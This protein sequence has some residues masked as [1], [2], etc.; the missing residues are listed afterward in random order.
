[1]ADVPEPKVRRALRAEYILAATIAVV[2]AAV[3]AI[4]AMLITGARLHEN[5]ARVVALV[6]QAR[7]EMIAT[8]RAQ[9]DAEVLAA[10]YI[11]IG[12]AGLLTDYANAKN[13]ARRNLLRLQ[14]T[15][16]G[17][18]EVLAQVERV[19]LLIERRFAVLDAEVRTPRRASS[20]SPNDSDYGAFRDAANAYS[21]LLNSRIDAA[22]AA[23]DRSRRSVD[24]MGVALALLSLVASALAIYALRRERDQWRVA[25][26]A[27]EEARKRAIASDLAKTRF[28]ATASHDMRQPL[29]ALT[30][31]LTALERRVENPEARGI[32]E[33]MERATQAMV[34]MFS[35]LLDLARIQAGVI[36]PDIIVFRL[37][38]VLDRIAAEHPNGKLDVPRT[39]LALKSDPVLVER[40][41]RNFVTNAMR[42]GGGSARI[43]ITGGVASAT[44]AVV[45]QGPGVPPR[46][47]DRIFEEFV[48]LD[49][50][51]EG[52]GLGLT[53]VKRIS[54]LID[55][56]VELSC[57]PSGG[58]RFSIR[59]P[60]APGD[61]TPDARHDVDAA[62]VFAGADVLVMD[63]EPLAR[64]AIAGMLRD[65]G[66]SVR[67]CGNEAELN[68]ILDDGAKPRLLVVDLRIDG[69]LSGVDI[70]ERAQKRVDP[71]PPIL[72]VTGDTGAETLAQLRAAGHAY[73]IKPVDPRALTQAAAAQLGAAPV[74]VT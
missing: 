69:E 43:E 47:R 60:I 51:G 8:T 19:S 61:P 9:A 3:I 74:S 52:L 33:K 21:E 5:E 58:A 27:A 1:M 28:L 70:G 12:R 50:R 29:H 73:L 25:R 46:D 53:I 55:A 20:A 7:M 16:A 49:S 45:D 31:Y 72:V 22:R 17:D 71:P 67:A 2:S 54:E 64:E 65:L 18:A 44:I 42:H 34:G 63:D 68:A 15:V 32:V 62:S 35:S 56:P 48:R 26:E 30:L 6:R 41:L 4:V 14:T 24:L 11:A 36:Q 59:V 10:R 13:Q 23:E 57:P 39:N 40:V 37:Q 66:A 38:D